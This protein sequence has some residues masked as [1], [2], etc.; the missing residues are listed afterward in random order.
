MKLH[1]GFQMLKCFFGKL[2]FLNVHLTGLHE[3]HGKAPFG[4]YFTTLTSVEVLLINLSNYWC[5]L[6]YKVEGITLS[7]N[8]PHCVTFESSRVLFHCRSSLASA[9]AREVDPVGVG[10]GGGLSWLA[11]GTKVNVE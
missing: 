5:N 2:E 10:R 8:I 9:L 4:P 1:V 7:F 3:V 11:G 6:L